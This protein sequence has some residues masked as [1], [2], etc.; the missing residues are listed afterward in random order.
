MSPLRLVRIAIVAVWAVLLIALARSHLPGSSPGTSTDPGTLP[1]PSAAAADE[2]WSGIYLRGA[3][4][5][6]AH[7][8][9][10]PRDDGLH[11]EE[12][13]VMRLTV[14]DREQTVR[15]SLTAEAN[16][17]FTVRTLA[18]A[19][20]SDLGTFNVRGRVEGKR[21][22]LDMQTGTEHSEQTIPLDEPLF[23][24][25][26]A[27]VRLAS[28]GL[29]A[30]MQTTVRVF[31]PSAMQHQ[32]M[33][34][35]VVE[36]QD[37]VI[38]GISVPAWKLR[39]SFRG[40][41]SEVWIDAEGRMLRERGAMDLEVVRES[42]QTATHEGWADAPVDLMGVVAIPVAQPIE[43]ARERQHLAVRLGGLSGVA[44]PSDARQQLTDDVLVI[45]RES[46]PTESHPLPYTGAQWATDL[47]PTAFLQ[48]DHARVR[49]AARAAVGDA[50]DARSAA[51]RLRTWVYTTLEKRPAATIPNAL[52]VLE[53]GAGDCN[54]HA[55]LF[56]ALARAA[57]LP[58]RVV[59]G[60]VYQDGAF[61]YHAWNEVWLGDRWVSVDPA[62]DQMPADVT[63]LKLVE[64]GPDTHTALLPLIGSLS[65][66]VLPD[67]AG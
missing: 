44:V 22:L 20:S 31:D 13:S 36:P 45:R 19:L 47:E 21:L 64:G 18:A 14:L 37:L 56:A 40:I 48:S 55:V 26:A 59:A 10:T 16:P 2:Q 51:E 41:E 67:S 46:I 65:I 62:F 34:I 61:L 27:R 8:R 29:R 12:T 52:Q 1:L 24:P 6:Y 49:A 63:H 11:I 4:I 54:E 38:D 23:L 9:L 17:D 66:Q 32:P 25:A 43:Q 39:E 50:R 30:G 7:S 28:A 5:G 3:K 15:F 57:G 60:V 53:M 42:R 35:T 58:A 33:T